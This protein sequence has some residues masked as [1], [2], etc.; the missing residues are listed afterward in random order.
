M[1]ILVKIA[2]LYGAPALAILV[3]VVAFV[4]AFRDVRSGRQSRSRAGLR[5]AA[6]LLLPFAAWLLVWL[7]SDVSSFREAAPQASWD[8]YRPSI[9]L[10]LALLPLA[11]YLLVPVALLNIAFWLVARPRRAQ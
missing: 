1:P 9:G 6:T 3:A 8:T 10:L 5:Y 11:V 7:A 2:I 4:V